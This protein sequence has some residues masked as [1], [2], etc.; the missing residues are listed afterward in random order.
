MRSIKTYYSILRKKGVYTCLR[1]AKKAV[2]PLWF[3][4]SRAAIE[5]IQAERVSRKLW[6]KYKELIVKP[7]PF[8]EPE[9]VTKIIWICWLQGEGQ[10]PEIVKR[11]IASVR[12]KMPEYEVKV[13]TT[14][15][16][17]DFVS[18]PEHIVKKY[19][20][21]TIS[22]THFSD[23][24]R[25][26]LLV[27]HGGIWLDA[28]VLLT[29]V[30]SSKMTD[31]PLF[32]LQKSVLSSMPHAGS[33]WMLVAQKG[34]PILQR[35][36]DLLS[37]YWKRENRLCDYFLFHLFLA[38]VL[39]HNTQ[40]KE[41]LKAMTYVPNVDAHTLQFRLFENYTQSGWEQIIERS[42][43]HKLTWKFNH[44]EPLEKKGTYYDYILHHMHL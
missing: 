28:T 43:V 30:I 15:N 8:A 4:H 26:A 41:A 16:I 27:Q 11:C 32:F 37:A 19:Q 39:T 34:N 6:R 20:K 13:L 35:V 12:A 25:T 7:L 44:N 5:Q 24:L 23:I 2:W 31:A 18:L 3:T 33:S 9:E 10:A 40:G 29:G 38:L 14:E 1:E 17:F 21:G 42:A 22:F 36:L